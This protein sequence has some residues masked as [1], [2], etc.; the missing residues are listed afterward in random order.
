MLLA[1]GADANARD[2][3]GHTPLHL[4]GKLQPCST[5]LAKALL[6]GG[7]H[8]DCV[9]GSGA[10]FRTYQPDIYHTVQPINYL[11]LTCLAARAVKQY[12][13]DYKASG[14]LPVTLRAA[15]DEH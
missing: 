4:A 5:A 15:V 9:D 14:Q 12:A 3:A 1:V 7:A 10:T 11:R 6:E 13:L 2:D 8:L